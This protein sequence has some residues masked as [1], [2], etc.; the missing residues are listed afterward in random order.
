MQTSIAPPRSATC[1]GSPQAF[2]LAGV[3]RTPQRLLEHL[4]PAALVNTLRRVPD[5][6]EAKRLVSQVAQLGK[7]ENEGI[8]GFRARFGLIL[9]GVAARNLGPGLALEDAL[10]AR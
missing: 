5:N 3:D 4:D 2:D 9:E 1:S 8:A 6:A 10:R 7:T